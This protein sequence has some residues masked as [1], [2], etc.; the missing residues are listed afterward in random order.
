MDKQKRKT[1]LAEQAEYQSR[2]LP[3][4]P[5]SPWV[6]RVTE[7]QDKPGPVLIIKERYSAK[8][9]V[10]FS[11]VTP[12][13]LQLRDRGVL[14]G[15]ALRRCL[16][17]IRILVSSVCDEAGIPVD[18]HRYI[19][20]GH[21]GFRGNLPMNKEIGSKLSLIFKLSERISDMDRVELIAWRVER[22]SAEEAIYWLTRGTQFGEAPSR[23]AL[24]GMRIMLG[25]QSGDKGIQRMLEKLRK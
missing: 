10:E 6:L 15:Q 18:L 7:H 16:P 9:D 13:G 22:F 23:W 5:S 2:I 17:V 8:E 20:N 1:E 3:L 4:V 24:A 25:G 14:Y 12:K 19:G 21:I 11:N